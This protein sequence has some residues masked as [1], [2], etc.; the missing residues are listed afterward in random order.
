[1]LYKPSAVQA[2][3]SS[4]TDIVLSVKNEHVKENATGT[5]NGTNKKFVVA[6]GPIFPR[7]KKSIAPQPADVTAYLLKGTTYTETAVTAINTVTD[8]DT[9]IV[10]YGEVELTNAPAVETA[11]YVAVDYMESMV[12]YKL[13]SNKED[14]KRDTKDVTEIGTDQKQTSTGSKSRSLTLGGHSCQVR[15]NEKVG[16]E[17]VADQ[18][19]VEEGYELWREIEGL[20]E[21]LAYIN[22]KDP[23]G[24]FI[25]RYYYEGRADLQELYAL[26]TGDNPTASVQILVDEKV[27]MIVAEET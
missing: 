2:L 20:R 17:K 4:K 25:G 26:K 7:N 16:F 8:T 14:A 21:I 13:Q 19:G 5:I 22:A 10:Y 6:N 9:G 23:V 24:N 15:P 18:T 27:D 11:D 1:M 3:E 12:F